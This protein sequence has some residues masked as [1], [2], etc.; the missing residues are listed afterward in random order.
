MKN[1]DKISEAYNGLLGKEMMDSSRERIHWICSHAK[2]EVILDVGC[3]QGIAS[4]ILAREGKK[5]QGI[6]I[7]QESVDYAENSLVDEDISTKGNVEFECVDFMS[8]RS[9]DDTAYDCVIMSEVLEHLA[10]PERFIK[11]AYD[12]LDY[13]GRIVVTVPFGINDYHDHKRTYYSKDLYNEIAKYFHVETVEFMQGYIGMVALKAHNHTFVPANGDL[14]GRTEKAFFS[15][16]RVLINRLKNQ[17]QNSKQWQVKAEE[18]LAES[19]QW[20]VKAEENLAESKQWQ[21]KAEENLAESKQWQVKAEENLAISKEWQNKVM[22]LSEWHGKYNALSSSKLGRMQLSIWEKRT[23]KRIQKANDI[24]KPNFIK[25][26]AKKSSLLVYFVRK[27]RGNKVTISEV[28]Q[29]IK[30]IEESNT[31][32]ASNASN[33]QFDGS[34]VQPAYDLEFLKRIEY[35]LNQIPTSNAG[36]FYRKHEHKLALITDDFMFN[37]FKDVATNVAVLHPDRWQNEILNSDLL[38]IISGWKGMDNEWWGYGTEGSDSRKIIYEIINHCKNQGIPTAFY[39]IEDPP[40]YKGF[41]GIAK[42][43]DYVFTT[44]IEMVPHYQEDCGHKHVY[45]LMFGINPLFHNPVGSCSNFKLHGIIFSGSWYN[46]YPERKVDMCE[47]FDGVLLSSH[48]LKIIDRNFALN[49]PQY[50]FPIRY[51]PYISPGVP[52]ELLQKLHKLYDWAINFNT[53]KESQ[54][55]FANRVYELE[56]TGNLLLSN[57]SVGVNSYLPIVYT[58]QSSQEVARIL[59][60]LTPEEIKERQAVGI[61]HAMT[62]NTCFD[63]YAIIIEKIGLSGLLQ[64]RNIAVVVKEM[65][66]SLQHQFEQ[67]TYPNKTMITTDELLS[68]YDEF[69]MVAFFAESME[70]GAFYLEDMINAFKY[71][72]RDYI[73]KDAYYNGDVYIKGRQ[74]DFVNTISS[75]Y[76][77]VFWSDSFNAKL[78]LDL[79]ETGNIEMPKGYSVDCLQFNTSRASNKRKTNR[80]YKIS[81]IIPVYN[82]GLHLYGKAF[83]SLLRSSMFNDMEIILIDAGSR[84]CVTKHYVNYLKQRYD[85]VYAF[86]FEDEEDGS[87]LRAYN[88]GVE[89]STSDYLVFLNPNDEAIN[90]AYV[91]LYKE[92]IENKCDLVIGNIRIFCK[93]ENFIDGNYSNIYFNEINYDTVNVN[94]KEFLEKIQLNPIH[95]Q[96]MIIEKKLFTGNSLKQINDNLETNIAVLSICSLQLLAN[97]KCIRSLDLPICIHYRN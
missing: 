82:N 87:I 1:V 32:S 97:A 36:R 11:R 56:A 75:K 3:S 85:N 77:A 92:A 7:C 17:E 44:A 42:Q 95:I 28:K 69:D 64:T 78:L 63:R 27:L 23:K 49:N 61:R 81:V 25:R 83:G 50:K 68:R 46:K 60:T 14:F 8:Y 70:Y 39:S 13:S 51:S 57:Y 26:L 9:S 22:A 4:I 18:N 66:Q 73:T 31:L 88:K 40:H 72:D 15:H 35:R 20:Q 30:S 33:E 71:T 80:N 10:D 54:T 59:D 21:V 37:T 62:D 47:M 55:M 90:D 52:H 29:E 84:D 24:N 65:T 79:P 45:P 93:K 48:G 96:A 16:E 41:I 67:Q 91:K 2:G 53:V 94:R 19:K 6:D 89:M 43:C 58:V 74:H 86:F 76:C 34:N 12:I 5:V 38:L